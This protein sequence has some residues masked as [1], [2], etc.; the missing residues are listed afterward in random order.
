[1]PGAMEKTFWGCFH[2][3]KIKVRLEFSCLGFYLKSWFLTKSQSFFLRLN[4]IGIG[5]V[6]PI[7]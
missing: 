4:E 2:K 7:L 5:T 1:M 6:V 3:A